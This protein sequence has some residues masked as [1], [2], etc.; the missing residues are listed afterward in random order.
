[1]LMTI[2]IPQKYN[3]RPARSDDALDIAELVAISSDG[4]AVIEWQEEALKERCDSLEIAE[5]MYQIP[6]QDYSYSSATLIGSNGEIAGM[7]LAFAI[8]SGKSRNPKN[9]QGRGDENVFAPYIYLEEP[10]GILPPNKAVT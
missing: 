3:L 10:I 7:L 4:I 8:P 1:M 5:R 9:R 6:H 2:E